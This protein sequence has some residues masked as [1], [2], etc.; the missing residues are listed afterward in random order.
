M[1]GGLDSFREIVV[2]ATKEGL[3]GAVAC[4]H[5]TAEVVVTV[6]IHCR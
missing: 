6:A 1:I 3:Y 4:A 5:D 2:T